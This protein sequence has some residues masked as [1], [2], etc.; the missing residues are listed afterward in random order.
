[1]QASKKLQEMIEKTDDTTLLGVIRALHLKIHLRD[2]DEAATKVEQSP[3]KAVA[4]DLL[5]SKLI[6]HS[7]LEYL[8]EHGP[9]QFST[10][11]N[12]TM[13]RLVSTV[14]PNETERSTNL[15]HYNVVLEKYIAWKKDLESVRELDK[16]APEY[17]IRREHLNQLR[18]TIKAEI[19]GVWQNNFRR[20]SPIPVESE[21]RR[22]LERYK[23]IFAAFPTFMKLAKHLVKEAFW[24][25]KASE[26]SRDPAWL[27]T[28]IRIYKKMGESR[29]SKL[30]AIK[31]TCVELGMRDSIVVPRIQAPVLTFSSWKG[32]DRDGNPFVVASFS[33]EIF[34]EQK[35]FVLEE[36]IR[37]VESLV[38]HLTV[39]TEFVP[40]T[41]ELTASVL[42]DRKH[43]PYIS[44]IKPWEPYRAK[45]RY[46]LEKLRNTVRLVQ[47]VRQSAGATAKPLLG[48][49]LPGP[50]GYNDA[51]Q[52]QADVEVVYHSLLSASSKAQARSFVQDLS[53]LVNTFG[54]HLTSIDF[55][56]HSEQNFKAVLE[57]LELNHYAHASRLKS[58]SER[59]RQ[60]VLL[61]IIGS[62]DD[63]DDALGEFNPWILPSM[64]KVS[65]DTWETILV[66]QDAARADSRA[67]GK[68]IISMCSN[69]SDILII[70][71]MMKIVGSLESVGGVITSCDHD[72][73]GLFETVED[74]KAAPAIIQDF[75]S[76]KMIRDYIR[77]HRHGKV[78]MMMGYS[79][80]VRDGS[81]LA[82]DSQITRTSLQLQ[83]L[84]KE[85]NRAHPSDVPI[86][87]VFYRGRG[88][89]IPR[90]FGGSVSKAVA[91]QLVTTQEEDHTE[92]NR[93]L[94]RY[95][96]V[97]STIDHLHS[98]YSAHV[99]RQ[100]AHI[101]GKT[102]RYQ[103]YFDF[104]GRIS[105]I[106]WS[107]L[108]Q[109]SGLG[110]QYFGLLN[111]YSI[112]P[113]L[114]KAHFASRP[115]ARDGITYNIDS[116]RAIPFTMFLAQMREFTNAYYG[117]GTAFQEGSRML[118][119][120]DHATSLLLVAAYD[121]IVSK[122][123]WNSENI[124]K[125]SRVP[126]LLQ[127]LQEVQKAKSLPT[128]RAVLDAAREYTA[129]CND[130][131]ISKILGLYHP[132]VPGIEE[133]AKLV[134]DCSEGGQ[135][136]VEVLREMYH[137]YGPFQYCIQNKEQALIIRSS[138]IVNLYAAKAT[139]DERELLDL[140]HREAELTKKWILTILQQTTLVPKTLTQD[141]ESP[142]LEVLHHIQAK[143][144]SKAKSS[145]S[146][147]GSR[148]KQTEERK[149]GVYIQMTILAISE[150]LGFAG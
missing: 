134:V 44:N 5:E 86:K 95:S 9:E 111:K 17:R 20:A 3:A 19:E 149:L 52:L 84:E 16:F 35:A 112:L 2:L 8:K 130:D 15:M 30:N 97:S 36:Y 119:N 98:L 70:L 22:L 132:V 92:Q 85:I 133:I 99:S 139:T 91:A 148:A 87:F 6:V 55:R 93:F 140:T 72:V 116:I 108:V 10:F 105:N 80:S 81:S 61:G 66:F 24:L 104:F 76:I 13:L 40:V 56:Q 58:G 77:R 69:V 129:S 23:T 90:G 51:Q 73:T 33:N 27:A 102:M 109:S 14:H 150:A 67:V 127:L 126:S 75:L 96:S 71:T 145:S 31:A 146:L 118:E 147:H 59:D 110:D 107:E 7:F 50:V 143:F 65:R 26:L 138:R 94:R 45:M 101:P 29:E 54:L 21:A 62:T 88:D 64:S 28:F 113:H 103:R 135:T 115:V 63:K 34:I 122:E 37:L 128:V 60:A 78:T 41:E 124:E 79:D 32:G 123:G 1:M 12:Q 11:I 137:S 136:V 106:K 4:G 49:T 47:S 38:D 82:S 114:P 131:L 74:L 100:V 141:F 48:R 121:Q 142:E 120:A 68:F 25:Y 125:D 42:K 43:F 39:S 83:A 57:Y 18:R 117:T 144:L 89:T 53:I 46:I